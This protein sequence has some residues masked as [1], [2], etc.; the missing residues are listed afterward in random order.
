MGEFE[1]GIIKQAN[2]KRQPLPDR[3]ANAPILGLGLEFY[4]DAFLLLCS[5]RG[6]ES[7]IP[8]RAMKD[9]ATE[10]G[11]SDPD[12]RQDFYLILREMDRT[13]IDIT[14]KKRSKLRELNKTKSKSGKR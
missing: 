12:D 9:Y 11:I 7:A 8:W 10:L 2:Q 14:A 3:I 4:W 13:L 5:E 6:S 1:K